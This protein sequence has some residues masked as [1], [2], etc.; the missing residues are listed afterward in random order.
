MVKIQNVRTHTVLIIYNSVFLFF[1]LFFIHSIVRSFSRQPCNRP[2]P[3]PM[4]VLYRVRTTAYYFSFQCLLISLRSSSSCLHPLP[5]LP[6][7]PI[8]PSTFP[9]VTCLRRQF[10]R[11]MWPIELT[12]LLFLVRKV[13]LSSLMLCNTS[14][15]FTRSVQLIFCILLQHHISKLL[16]YF[17]STFSSVCPSASYKATLHCSILLTSSLSLSSICWWK[18]A[19]L[20]NAAFALAFIDIIPRVHLAWLVV[21]PPKQL[22]YSTFFSCFLIYHNLDYG[23]LPRDSHYIPFFPI[24]FHFIE[25][26]DFS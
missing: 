22:K 7:I 3:L 23:W 19:F 16:R 2:Y 13:F 9:S 25:F 10:L 20:L 24:H 18:R 11:K 26:S 8:F 1:R 17:W 14:S 6:V 21:T 12:F 5:R 4:P 15:F